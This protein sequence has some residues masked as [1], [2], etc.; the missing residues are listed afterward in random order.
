MYTLK[1]SNALMDI[2]KKSMAAAEIVRPISD[3]SFYNYCVHSTSS[4]DHLRL[5]R[6][7]RNKDVGQWVGHF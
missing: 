4:L 5:Y 1:K 7:Q 6:I 3:S 2:T